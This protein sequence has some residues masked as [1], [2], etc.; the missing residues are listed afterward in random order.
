MV[1]LLPATAMLEDGVASS[2][3]GEFEW[4]WYFWMAGNHTPPVMHENLQHLKKGRKAHGQEVLGCHLS[5]PR[6]VRGKNSDLEPLWKISS[7]RFI[8]AQPIAI[9]EYMNC[10]RNKIGLCQLYSKLQG[11]ILRH[12]QFTS[13]E[14]MASSDVICCSDLGTTR[15]PMYSPW[16]TAGIPLW[17]AKGLT[18]KMTTCLAFG[19]PYP[20]SRSP[21]C[22]D[23]ASWVSPPCRIIQRRPLKLPL[24]FRCFRDCQSINSSLWCRQLY[25]LV[26]QSHRACAQNAARHSRWNLWPKP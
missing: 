9:L 4:I 11:S 15:W 16:G 17:M 14:S 26:V 1:E 19:S 6:V 22:F 8:P 20:Q 10:L 3:P 18:P 7:I 25:I 5:T 24:G 13:G 2:L 23:I 12:S 21:D